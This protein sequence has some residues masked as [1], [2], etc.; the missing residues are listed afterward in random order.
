[1]SA[2]T[3]ALDDR[4]MADAVG[5]AKA[6]WSEA[7]VPDPL[8]NADVRARP[9]LAAEAARRR[10][11]QGW[12]LGQ[13]R[14]MGYP[15]PTGG[16]RN[17]T[18]LDP[19]A[20]LGYRR[21][22]GRVI[23]PIERSLGDNVFN[24]RTQAFGSSWKTVPWRESHK[25]Y[26][27]TLAAVRA[28]PGGGEARLDVKNHYAT[29]STETLRR[30]LHS[31]GASPGAVDDLTATLNELQEIPGLPSGLPIGPEASGPLGT[32]ALLPF[33]RCVEAEG[34]TA[35]RWTDDSVVPLADKGLYESLLDRLT[36]QLALGGQ[37][38]N[39]GK[40]EYVDH[41][42]PTAL[43]LSGGGGGPML[44]ADPVTALELA[45]FFKLPTGV[46]MALGSL[47][48]DH[49][50]R[51]VRILRENPWI[52]ERFPKQSAKY[53]AQ[54][55]DD[56]DWDWV[57]EAVMAQATPDNA[58][59]QMH[60][61][62]ALPGAV[63]SSAVA[64]GLFDRAAGMRRRELAPLADQ[65][66]ATAGRSTERGHV[67]QRRALELAVELGELNAQRSLLSAFH[68]GG[69]DRTGVAGLAHLRRNQPDLAMTVAWVNPS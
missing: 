54:F 45:A 43:E 19:I 46:T 67:R 31:A 13:P 12:V 2:L 25:A 17:M 15:K 47:R 14:P 30:T 37:H 60:L 26:R 7:D 64:G 1:M 9:D 23:E 40:C 52:I 41:D 8:G 10:V 39:L 4:S 56:A 55:A 63:L 35:L 11:A 29:V 22:V 18:R 5:A 20:D 27:G 3:V 62:R 21:L 6:W 33:D 42:D 59:A 53:L 49:D 24:T 36:T 16:L 66:F 50:R 32:H 57:L 34:L 44:A 61:S 65:L 51:A 38:L 28:E 58:A 48:R 69:I 68:A